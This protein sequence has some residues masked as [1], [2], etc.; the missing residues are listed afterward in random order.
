VKPALKYSLIALGIL[1][2]LAPVLYVLA[3]S[4]ALKEHGKED[5]IVFRGKRIEEA[6]N[7]YTREHGA[8][9]PKL[10]SL[11]P[12]FMQ[13]IPSIPEISRVDYRLSPRW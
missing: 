1:A 4:A 5:R 13:S 10:E 9:P 2:L 3:I 7:D 12:E 6:I 8:P 11:V